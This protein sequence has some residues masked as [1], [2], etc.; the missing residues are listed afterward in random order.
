MTDNKLYVAVHRVT[1]LK[2]IF[3]VTDI[4]TSRHA[5]RYY[6]TLKANGSLCTVKCS[7]VKVGL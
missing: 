1:Y 4:E 7:F 2:T 3:T 6:Y 5:Q